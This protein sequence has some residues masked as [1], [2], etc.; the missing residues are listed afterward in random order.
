MSSSLLPTLSVVVPNYNHAQYL[1][2][3]LLA[4]LRQ[5]VQPFEVIVLDDAS[6]D[7]SVEVIRRIAAQNPLIRLVQNEKN[8]GVMPNVNKGLDISRGDYVFFG[9]ADDEVYPGLFEKSLN[10]LAQHPQAAFSCTIGD[11]REVAT[12]LHWHMGVGMGD[13][14]CYISPAQIVNLERRDRFFFVSNTA[15]YRRQALLEVKKFIPELKWHA[16]WFALY[17]S[18]LRHGFCFLP[19][20]LGRL[21]ILKTSFLHSGR[22]KEAAHRAL[23]HR[24]LELLTSP[25]FRKE[26]DLVREA[27]SLYVFGMPM[28]KLLLSQPEYRRFLTPNFL[29]KN[30][31]QSTKL[32][33]KRFLPAPLGNLYL[34]IAGYRKR[35][36]TGTS[37][38][39]D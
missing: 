17:A 39:C 32:F 23:L 19:E 13:K 27:G 35:T 33:V 24:I 3:C 37:A 11:W 28:L 1:Q 4:I 16:D 9:A 10:L 14:P 15:V 18:G 2:S 36:A 21:N 26:G 25:E 29:R 38:C 12:G 7:N 31:W 20:V 5:S 30:L 22:S 6:I 8:I 34:R